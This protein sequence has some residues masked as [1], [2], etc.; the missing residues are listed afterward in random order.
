MRTG[1]A[2]SAAEEAEENS[3]LVPRSACDSER[4]VAKTQGL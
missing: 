1:S 3:S 4:S 2:G